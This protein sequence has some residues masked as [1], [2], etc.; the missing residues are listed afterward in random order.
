[1]DDQVDPQPGRRAGPPGGDQRGHQEQGSGPGPGRPGWP[2]WRWRPGWRSPS[3][4]SR[5]ARR[6]GLRPFTSASAT[7]ARSSVRPGMSSSPP[8][9]TSQAWTTYTSTR[10]WPPSHATKIEP[11]LPRRTRGG[12]SQRRSAGPRDPGSGEVRD[13]LSA[14]PLPLGH[15]GVFAEGL[16]LRVPGRRQG[17]R[18]RAPRRC[19]M[20]GYATRE[21]DKP[22][23]AGPFSSVGRASP[24]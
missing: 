20:L 19:C 5:Q 11:A 1:V 6:S 22:H 3:A 12:C 13:A 21:R 7:S 23:V 4:T 17:D 8:R 24:W 2:P 14:G 9:T 15:P 16:R 18:T 10:P